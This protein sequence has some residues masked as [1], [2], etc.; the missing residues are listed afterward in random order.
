[1]KLSLHVWL[2]VALGL[3]VSVPAVAFAGGWLGAGA[4]QAGRE[5]SRER[6]AVEVVRTG[7]YDTP[8]E[9]A[10]V[11]DELTRLGVDAQVGLAPGAV[12]AKQAEKIALSKGRCSS[13]RALAPTSG[14]SRRR[15]RRS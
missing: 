6:Q 14:P 7:R 1:M 9:R 11:T 10:R 13:H 2:L 3:A 5:T 4:W 8:A 15:A 12:D